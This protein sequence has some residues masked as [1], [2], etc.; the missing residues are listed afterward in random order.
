MRF[1]GNPRKKSFLALLALILSAVVLALIA[2][3]EKT[4]GQY[5]RLIY[6]HAA[7]TWVGLS[8]FAVSGVFAL[9]SFMAALA[10]E[11]E[12]AQKAKDLLIDLSSA[13]Q[14]T[15]IVFWTASAALGS[16][17][18][19]LTWGGNWWIEPRIKVALF[20]LILALFIYQ[21]RQMT[22]KKFLIAGL[23]L[24]LPLLILLLL[25]VTGKLVHPHN[26]FTQS[27]S[28]RMKLFAALITL[29]FVVAAANCLYL[30]F[31]RQRLRGV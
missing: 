29:V 14:S 10:P 19:Y 12:K 25:S 2:P 28:I 30:F 16:V 7:V 26:A 8:M 4:L 13:G 6:I 24:S 9:L 22:G 1:T 31:T 15:A 11:K 5:I 23:N 27:D 18:A 17:A 21:L 20:I 3:E